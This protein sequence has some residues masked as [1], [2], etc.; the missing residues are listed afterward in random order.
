MNV[1][2]LS[3]L[4]TGSMNR[5]RHLQRVSDSFQTYMPRTDELIY[6]LEELSLSTKETST[7]RQLKPGEM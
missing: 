3:K 6:S 1:A 7:C 4:V 5:H 2:V